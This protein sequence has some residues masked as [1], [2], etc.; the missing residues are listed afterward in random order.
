MQTKT[1]NF[2]EVVQCK[3]KSEDERQGENKAGRDG[4]REEGR[5]GGRK[6]GKEG[7][8]VGRSRSTLPATLKLPSI[9][10]LMISPK[11][12]FNRKYMFDPVV[13]FRMHSKSENASTTL[14]QMKCMS[15]TGIYASMVFML[16]TV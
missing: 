16:K 3:R 2:V 13:T 10:P 12:V 11:G 5:E 4:E 8:K 14:G 6:E 7:T 9:V 15:L 1:G